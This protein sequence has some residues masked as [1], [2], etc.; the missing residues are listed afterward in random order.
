[1]S[2][3]MSWHLVELVWVGRAE[4]HRAICNH[5]AVHMITNQRQEQPDLPGRFGNAVCGMVFVI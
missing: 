1:M 5:K 3:Q 4:Q 2:N